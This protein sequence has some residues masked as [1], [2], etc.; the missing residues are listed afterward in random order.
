[1]QPQGHSTQASPSRELHPSLAVLPGHLVWRA[2]ARVV[3]ALDEVLPAGVDLHAHAVLLALDGGVTRSQQEL[4]DTVSTSRTTITRVAADLVAA[5]L[6]ERVRNPEDRRSYAL[7]RTA[8]GTEAAH[9]WQLHA[10]DLQTS[11]TAGFTAAERRDLHDLLLRVIEDEV[12][13]DAP[14][15][16]RS[17][18]GFVVSRAHFRLHRDFL[19]ALEPLRLEPRLFGALT[20]LTATGPIAQAELSRGLGGSGASVVQIADDLEARGLVERRRD[21]ADR[22]TPLLHLLPEAAAVTAAA[23]AV[24]EDTM[25][26]RL[27]PLDRDETHRLVGLLQ[28]FVVGGRP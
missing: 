2:H 21:P 6:V 22:R 17:S 13:P 23:R 28:R 19:A 10:D 20:A 25:E 14:E 7:T 16:L 9:T 5:G 12:A 11:L 1:M 15:A 4:A 26:L 27:G 18:L 24:A 3:L 8:A